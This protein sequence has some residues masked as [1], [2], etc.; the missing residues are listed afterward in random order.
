I[1]DANP[2]LGWRDVQEILAITARQVGS[3]TGTPTAYE[4]YTGS[5]NGA[6][7]W[8][9]GGM[10]F[11]NDYGFGLVD[12]LAAVRLAESWTTQG[13]SANEVQTSVTATIGTAIPDLGSV[14]RVFTIPTD[15]RIDHVELTVDI[16]HPNRGDLEIRLTSPDGTVSI[17]LDNPLNGT[18]TTDNLVFRLGSNA[19]WGEGSAGNWTVTITD[20]K[21][22]NVGI[23]NSL[24][25]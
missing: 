7:N 10:H 20:T 4:K 1:L 3:T 15:I 11:S 13:T 12:A 14:S 2:N 25:I 23:V 22:G 24:T 16:T 17:L 5:F 19:F 9:G 6:D 18:D 21:T 8:N